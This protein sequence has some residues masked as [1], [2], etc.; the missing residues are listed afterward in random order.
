MSC[1]VYKQ[2]QVFHEGE[3]ATSIPG[4][5]S[6]LPPLSLKRETLVAIGQMTSQNL[7]GKKIWQGRKRKESVG[8]SLQSQVMSE[9]IIYRTRAVGCGKKQENNEQKKKFYPEKNPKS[10]RTMLYQETMISFSL[11]YTLTQQDYD[12]RT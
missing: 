10:K 12:W 11:G 9:L 3:P 1:F 4:S 5:L 6:L 2:Q 7:G 8:S